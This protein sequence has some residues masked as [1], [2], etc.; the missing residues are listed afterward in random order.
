[1]K[2]ADSVTEYPNICK[3]TRFMLFE[4]RKHYSPAGIDSMSICD[5]YILEIVG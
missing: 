3:G 5:T 2:T 1:M 4:I